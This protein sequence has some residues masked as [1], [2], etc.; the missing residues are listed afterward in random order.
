MKRLLD[1]VC[2]YEQTWNELTQYKMPLEEI[3]LDEVSGHDPP[4][5]RKKRVKENDSRSKKVSVPSLTL[6][7]P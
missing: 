2:W 4:G 7:F 6:H 3:V 5:N 1:E